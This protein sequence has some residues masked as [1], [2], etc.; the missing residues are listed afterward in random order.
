MALL[1]SPPPEVDSAAS[2]QA[3]QRGWLLR[4]IHDQRVAFLLVGSLNTLIGFAWFVFFHF[5]VG[6][7]T[8]YMVTLLCAHVAAV[9]CAF[10]LHRRLVFKVRGH[11]LLDL[12][13]FEV[14]NLTA[15]GI[16][17][18]LLPIAVELLGLPVL[19][20]QMLVTGATVVMSYFAHR[21][22]SFH[23][24]HHATTPS[25]RGDA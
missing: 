19:P 6:A 11:V 2:Q 3:R 5:T 12:A 9:L 10:V 16:N 17:A 21:G 24:R 25:H 8:G 18:A 7:R 22:F 20:A 23:R 15:L 14:V 13:R 1:P 4:V